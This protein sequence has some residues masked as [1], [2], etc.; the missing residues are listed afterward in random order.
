[1]SSLLKEAIID[2]KALKEA[3]LKNAESTIIDKYSDEVKEMVE[4]ILEQEESPL[5]DMADPM[6]LEPDTG[7]ESDPLTTPTD[8]QEVTDDTIPLASTN[9]LSNEEGAN[10]DK[11]PEEG[12][13]VEFDIDLGILEEAIQALDR[14]LNEDVEVEDIDEDLEIALDEDEELE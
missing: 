1:M 14:E 10:L 5:G 3:A 4:N 12:D 6:A 8:N 13:A 9:N 2:A 11:T 7:E